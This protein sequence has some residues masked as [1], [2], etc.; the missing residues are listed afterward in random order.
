MSSNK[1]GESKME[2]LEKLETAILEKTTELFELRRQEMVDYTAKLV[3]EV[4]NLER[5][6]VINYDLYE[7]N[8]RDH[9]GV[10]V[11]IENS[12][13]ALSYERS[14]N[15]FWST[16]ELEA[17]LREACTG[18]RHASHSSGAGWHYESY[19][20]QLTSYLF[21]DIGTE[22]Q[23]DVNKFIFSNYNDELKLINHEDGLHLNE[24]NFYE[25]ISDF[26]MSNGCNDVV[27]RD[28]GQEYLSEFPL[29]D[30]YKIGENL[31]INK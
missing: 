5:I 28:W 4:S 12:L 20:D 15:D 30:L 17:F 11:Q 13:N 10:L 8:P 16:T 25:F 14:S 6:H 27:I 26:S 31:H 24:E 7:D 22:I 2:A 29:K 19:Y 21:E 1:K 18:K 23:N 3:Y 9:S